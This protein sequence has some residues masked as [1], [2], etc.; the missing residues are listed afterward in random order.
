M[1]FIDKLPNN[2]SRSPNTLPAMTQLIRSWPCGVF[3]FSFLLSINTSAR[4][5]LSCFENDRIWML[6]W[7]R[8]VIIHSLSPLNGV[9]A[10]FIKQ[11]GILLDNRNKKIIYMKYLFLINLLIILASLKS[12]WVLFHSFTPDQL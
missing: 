11:L 5:V 8:N 12:P 3:T 10:L 6:S 4:G 2:S 7:S 1:M 9:I